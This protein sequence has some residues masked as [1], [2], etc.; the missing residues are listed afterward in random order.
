MG[1]DCL[2]RFT[3]LGNLLGLLD[4]QGAPRGR[5]APGLARPARRR[6]LTPA[7]TREKARAEWLKIRSNPE[8]AKGKDK[9]RGFDA[10]EEE[11]RRKTRDKGHS[12]DGPDDD[13]GM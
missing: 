10:G 9:T 3:G 5:T 6:A 11:D 2:V 8:K 13:F 12:R 7:E 4:S 1:N